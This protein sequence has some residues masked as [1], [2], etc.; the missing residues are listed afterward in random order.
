MSRQWLR[1]LLLGGLC[2]SL[3][4]VGVGCA[5]VRFL[6]VTQAR[7]EGSGKAE[8]FLYYPPK[9]CLLVVPGKDGTCTFQTLSLPD[10]NRPHRL[11][12]KPGLGSADLS[13]SIQNGM[14]ASFAEKTDTRIPETIEALGGAFPEIA[15]GFKTL[16][17]LGFKEGDTARA[18]EF[19]TAAGLRDEVGKALEALEDALRELGQ[20]SAPEH[21]ALKASL[22]ALQA[23][24]N[25]A[26]SQS[27]VADEQLHDFV[28]TLDG[29]LQQWQVRLAFE[30]GFLKE[31]GSKLGT[32]RADA[33]GSVT[34]AIMHL[35]AASALVAQGRA[36][37][38][39]ATLP[40]L[41]E[42]VP[43]TSGCLELRPIEF[44]VLP[45]GLPK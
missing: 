15:S 33:Y 39:A 27:T 44:P 1:G 29:K 19:R 10:V 24:R 20:T 36:A 6:E 14:L 26:N 40:K 32:A 34:R 17:A 37:S 12:F 9:L 5:G 30:Q 42:V 41:Y 23:L 21:A 28:N 18:M 4:G 7:S 31:L 13:F 43:S 22:A 16:A 45:K 35:E 8:G 25:E 3:G 2:V 11:R 38:P